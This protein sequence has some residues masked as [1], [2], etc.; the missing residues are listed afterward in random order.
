VTKILE[1]PNSRQICDSCDYDMIKP[2]YAKYKI[3]FTGGDRLNL[4]FSCF[5]KL[6]VELMKFKETK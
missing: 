1:T 3:Q 2:T 5:D 6:Y 4:C